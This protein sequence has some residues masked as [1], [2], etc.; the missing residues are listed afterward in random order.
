MSSK[1]FITAL[2]WW[3]MGLIVLLP[4]AISYVWRQPLAI[5][6]LN[7][8]SAGFILLLA[9]NILLRNLKLTKISSRSLNVVIILFTLMMFWGTLFSSPIQSVLGPWTSR[10]LQPLIVGYGSYLM[11]SQGKIE[12]TNIFTALWL[13]LTLLTLHGLAQWF[14]LIDT[15]NLGRLTGPH[16]FPNSFARILIFLQLILLPVLITD[17][18]N[19][20]ILK[21]IIWLASVLVLLGT[22]SYAGIAGLIIGSIFIILLLPNQ[23]KQLKTVSLTILIL[24]ISC[25]ALFRQQLPKYQATTS[26]SLQTRQQFW[27]IAWETIKTKPITGIG[28]E[29]WERN[30]LTLARTYIH[31]P[32]EMII[33]TTSAQPHNVYLD[34]WLRGGIIGLLAVLFFLIWP[35]Y[36]G[37]RHRKNI[38]ATVLGLAGLGVALIVFGLVDDPIFSDDAMAFLWLVYFVFLVK[39]AQNPALVQNTQT[40]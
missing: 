6:Y 3:L 4:E 25:G 16:D 34:G 5:S 33:E 30:Y 19:N 32:D 7:I 27:H 28:L 24:I 37:V 36:Y 20:K 14:G 31:E 11:L 2:R 26:T 21:T 13:S 18:A 38:D 22:E 39:K 8:L 9:L 40:S 1:M 12:K 10:F 17:S 23:Y 15:N 35:V 29:G